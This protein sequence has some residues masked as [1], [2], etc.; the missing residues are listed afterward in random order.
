[1]SNDKFVKRQNAN[2]YVCIN[3]EAEALLRESY[4]TLKKDSHRYERNTWIIEI[5]IL[6]SNQE[7]QKTPFASTTTD[8]IALILESQEDWSCV[9]YSFA[10]DEMCFAIFVNSAK[11][12]RLREDVRMECAKL[13]EEEFELNPFVY[14]SS[15]VDSYYGFSIYM[16]AVEGRYS[17]PATGKEL[18]HPNK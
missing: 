15:F 7:K 6:K 5:V 1:M 12:L 13:F 3:E 18:Y 10:P 2:T 8:N 14:V 4:D 16:N 9:K 17:K 11:Q